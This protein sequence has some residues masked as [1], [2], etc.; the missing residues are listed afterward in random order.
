MR[1][2]AT[3]L[4]WLVIVLA[5]CSAPAPA[6]PA[7]T[8]TP[9]GPRPVTFL[10]ESGVSVTGR[11]Y[12]PSAQPAPAVVLMHGGGGDMDEWTQAGVAAWLQRDARASAAGFPPLPAGLDVAVLIFDF[13]GNWLE[14]GRAA[15]EAARELPGVDPRRG[16][17]RHAGALAHGQL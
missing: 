2:P 1:T 4:L 10:T 13:R 17:R 12:P 11:F 15:V 5:A 6:T 8:A 9:S 14:A 3:A 7:M 16:L